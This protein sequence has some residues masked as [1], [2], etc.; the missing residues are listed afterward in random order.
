MKETE[1]RFKGSKYKAKIASTIIAH[2]LGMRARSEGKMVFHFPFKR[3]WR[4]DNFLVRTELYLYFLSSDKVVLD[5][6]YLP[7][8]VNPFSIKF[9]TPERPSSV[10]LESSEE[11]DL[12]EGDRIDLAPGHQ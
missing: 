12:D 7:R 1:V 9:Y 10:L 6:G 8:G 5:T 3:R 2:F 4:I 11:L